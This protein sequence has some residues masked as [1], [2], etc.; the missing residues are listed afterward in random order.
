[1]LKRP[2]PHQKSCYK[3]LPLS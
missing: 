1:M 3:H 2:E